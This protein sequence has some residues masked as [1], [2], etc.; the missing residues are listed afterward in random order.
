MFQQSMKNRITSCVAATFLL[1]AGTA[2]A[3]DSPPLQVTA[4]IN[5]DVMQYDLSGTNISG[6]FFLYQESTVNS[7]YEIDWNITVN[8]DLS[9][10]V[11]GGYQVMQSTVTFTNLGLETMDVS[12][13]VA[14][15]EILMPGSASSALYGGSISGSLTGGELGGFLNSSPD[16][17]LYMAGIDSSDSL[18]SLYNTFSFA[19]DPFQSIQIPSQDFG[20]PVPSLPGDTTTEMNVLMSFELSGKSTVAFTSTFVAQIPAP[21]VAVTLGLGFLVPRRR[22]KA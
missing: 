15:T 12:L 16:N 5:G 1:T 9:A 14:L 17:P 8:N 19:T 6:N 10:G 3:G 11:A 4:G 2:F 13:D 22:R 20:V 18:A 21:G 7:E